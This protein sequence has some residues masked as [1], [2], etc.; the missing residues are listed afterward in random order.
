MQNQLEPNPLAEP[1]CRYAKV[2]VRGTATCLVACGKPATVTLHVCM[3]MLC[4]T[5]QQLHALH[6]FGRLLGVAAHSC[7]PPAQCR[8]PGTCRG[9]CHLGK[10]SCPV[11]KGVFAAPW[12]DANPTHLACPS[13]HTLLRLPSHIISRHSDAG[14]LG[15]SSW[16]DRRSSSFGPSR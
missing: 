8:L 4:G 3:C 1:G 2:Q 5:A 6:H 12:S 11:R 15:L 16:L 10:L 9:T 7:M 13:P 14:A